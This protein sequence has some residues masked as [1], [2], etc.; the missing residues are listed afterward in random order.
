MLLV[1]DRS[2]GYNR[3]IYTGYTHHLVSRII[4][5]SGLS[6]TKGARMTRKQPI[7]LVYLEYFPTR[8]QAIKRE[9]QLKKVSPFNQKK[10]KLELISKFQTKFGE[11]LQGTNEKLSEYFDFLDSLVQTM[12]NLEKIFIKAFNEENPKNSP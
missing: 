2:H 12:S 5:H 11:F 1:G 7:E 8:K 10:Y 6:N 4:Q 9:R 3:R